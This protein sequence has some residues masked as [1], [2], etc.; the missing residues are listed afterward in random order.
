[1]RIR[2]G[3]LVAG[4]ALCLAG[5]DALNADPFG[6]SDSAAVAPN[7]CAATGCP[8]AAQFCVARGYRPETDAYRRCLL[9]VEEN[10]R[11]GQ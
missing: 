6:D 3:L 5:C 10:L 11:R 4:L 7:G 8:Q 1:M 2:A 9:S